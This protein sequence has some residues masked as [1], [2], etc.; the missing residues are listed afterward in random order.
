MW[1]SFPTENIN[2]Q[3]IL[4]FLYFK[5]L[6]ASCLIAKE[7]SGYFLAHKIEINIEF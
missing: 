3:M 4:A 1:A 7:Y 6:E 2:Y 5:L